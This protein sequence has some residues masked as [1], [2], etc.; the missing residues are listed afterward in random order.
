MASTNL[1]PCCFTQN[2]KHNEPKKNELGFLSRNLGI[3]GDFFPSFHRFLFFKKST[4]SKNSDFGDF[5]RLNDDFFYYV[6]QYNKQKQPS[7]EIIG[8]LT[9]I[10]LVKKK[11]EAAISQTLPPSPTIT[12]SLA[13]GRTS[14]S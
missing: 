9:Y 2:E 1:F 14:S 6:A 7:T 3:T 4:Q 5:C 8:S 13:L 11:M 10:S 12:K